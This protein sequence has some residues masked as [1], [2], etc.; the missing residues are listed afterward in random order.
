MTEP[1]N[2][3]DP[4]EFADATGQELFALL[5]QRGRERLPGSED[6]ARFTALLAAALI[7]VAEILRNPV[8]RGRDPAA[9]A[10][11]MVDVTARNLRALL[12]P[13]VDARLRQ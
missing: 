2:N 9:T 5:M 7:P 8:E 3:T 6:M 11:K 1:T 12:Q 4:M 10:D 13:A